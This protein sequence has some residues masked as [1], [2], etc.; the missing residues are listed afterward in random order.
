MLLVSL[1]V[2]AGRLPLSRVAGLNGGDSFSPVTMEPKEMLV[3]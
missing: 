1:I 2:V 3:Q